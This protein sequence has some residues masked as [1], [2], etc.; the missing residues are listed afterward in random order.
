MS[1][2]TDE[3]ISLPAE[4]E[5]MAAAFVDAFNSGN[6]QAMKEIFEPEA[7]RVISPGNYQAGKELWAASE[8]TLA[9]RLPISLS[10]RHAYAVGDIALLIIDYVHEGED[11][12]GKHVRIEGTATDIVRRGADG[13]WR[14]VIS[15]PSG[16]DRA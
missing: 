15:N 11:P 8:E 6:L 13:V 3:K 7:M 2:P 1:N 9:H 5:E 10:V 4:P 14:C 16:T 12:D